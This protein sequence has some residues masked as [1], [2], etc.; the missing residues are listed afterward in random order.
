MDEGRREQVGKSVDSLPAAA[1]V[2]PLSEQTIVLT[3]HPT[4]LA[5]G[6]SPRQSVDTSS[7]QPVRQC[8]RAE[9]DGK[10][11]SRGKGKGKESRATRAVLKFFGD[12]VASAQK[13]K[14]TEE[15][16]NTSLEQA[17]GGDGGGT[18]DMDVDRSRADGGSVEMGFGTT[19]S[20][21]VEATII[22]QRY[23]VQD[24]VQVESLH[25]GSS[26]SRLA[27]E[28]P[29][30]AHAESFV[31][32]VDASRTTKQHIIDYSHLDPHAQPPASIPLRTASRPTP[33]PR[34]KHRSSM[35]GYDIL[36]RRVRERSRH[37]SSTPTP[38]PTRSVSVGP[39]RTRRASMG[40]R[41]VTPAPEVG[42]VVTWV[43]SPGSR[44]EVDEEGKLVYLGIA[45]RVPTMTMPPGG[46]TTPAAPVQR[47][48]TVESLRK[49]KE[50]AEATRTP[51]GVGSPASSRRREFVK[52]LPRVRNGS[53]APEGKGNAV[54]GPSRIPVRAPSNTTSAPRR[55]ETPI[56]SAQINGPSREPATTT[57]TP[58]AG[59]RKRPAPFEDSTVQRVPRQYRSAERRLSTSRAA[60]EFSRAQ[61]EGSGRR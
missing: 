36:L 47:I 38:E 41:E 24:G 15:Q 8:E 43:P 61:R 5:N 45:P 9:Q 53:T 16:G 12:P 48:G 33:P 13:E 30:T 34:R 14:E 57:P 29:G 32:S 58:P 6:T 18:K 20:G 40:P 42:S 31:S 56:T 39:E 26:R 35:P 3:T 21:R 4:A 28:E 27:T 37:L 10:A 49:V 19:T 50:A 22:G 44:F 60:I 51:P 52:P 25:A 7:Y 54:A 2:E 59:A 11:S 55:Q 23:T 1:V 46:N 17:D